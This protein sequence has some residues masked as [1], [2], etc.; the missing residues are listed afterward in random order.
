MTKRKSET[1]NNKLSISLESKLQVYASPRA[2]ILARLPWLV[3]PYDSLTFLL[4]ADLSTASQTLPLTA[5]LAIPYLVVRGINLRF[6][7]SSTIVFRFLSVVILV[8]LVVSAANSLLEGTV[9]YPVN[10]DNRLLTWPRQALSMI[11][12]LFSFLMFQ[13][14]ILRTRIPGTARWILWGG[15]PSLLLGA[16][17]IVLGADRVQGFS[18]EPSHM[19]DML[20]FAFL[21]ACA[22]ADSTVRLRRF[23]AIFG[24]VLLMAT[25]S[26]T[27]FLKALLVVLVYFYLRGQ[28][29][30]GVFWAI[31]LASIALAI[32]NFFPDNYVF[33]I[34]RFMFATYE[35][36]GHLLGAGS[37]VDRFYSFVGPISQLGGPHGW[38]GYGF[39]GDTVYFDRLFDADTAN[40]IR[41]VKGEIVSISSLQGKMLMYG[42]VAGYLIYLFAWKRSLANVPRSHVA[43][44][45]I[46][47]VFASSL[48]SLG[49]LFLP[50]VWLWLAIGTCASGDKSLAQRTRSIT[51]YPTPAN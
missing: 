18:S 37:F 40:A 39:G 51:R 21:P 10:V 50:Y 6:N 48:F 14:A 25:F 49:P 11:L 41:E 22:L 46:P 28:L 23:F 36:T 16:A 2:D 45:M 43:R 12:G 31:V 33:T 35:Q 38:L 20:V 44:V 27:G 5:L 7:H 4:G 24:I 32:L 9:G 47:A 15:I 17:Q 26:T 42:G 34:F 3:L 13:D 1:L 8:M 30:R 19:A 29:G